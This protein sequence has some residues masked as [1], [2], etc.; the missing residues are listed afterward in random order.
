MKP[1][2]YRNRLCFLAKFLSY[3]VLIRSVV[4]AMVLVFFLPKHACGN[5]NI[6]GVNVA[7]PDETKLDAIAAAVNGNGGSWGYITVVIQETDR[8]TARWNNY[9]SALRERKLIPVVRLATRAEGA[10]WRRPAKEDSGSWVSFLQSLNWVT[11]ERYVILFNEPNNAR[12]WGGAVNPEDYGA[13]AREFATQLNAAS[14]DYVVMLAGFDSAAPTQGTSYLDQVQFLER[15]FATFPQQEIQ[16]NIK[17][18]ASHSYPNPG[19]RGKPN[20]TGRNSIRNYQW[21]L[22]WLAGRG[23]TGKPVFITETGWPVTSYDEQ[24]IATYLEQ[25]Y[26]EVW[27][28]D[29]RVKA[30]TPFLFSYQTAPFDVWA[31]ERPGGGVRPVYDRIKALPKIAGTPVLAD[32]SQDAIDPVVYRFWSDEKRGHFFTISPG[33]RDWVIQTFATSTWRFE[34]SGFSAL[35]TQQAGSIPVYRF[36]SN[37]QQGHFYTANAGEKVYIEKTFPSSVW[38]YETVAFYVF[39]PGT[40]DTRPVYRFWSPLY[41]KHFYTANEGEKQYIESNFP[42]SVWSYEQIAWYVR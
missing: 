38:R 35:A 40:P 4:L 27:F 2:R 7:S 14:P 41:R 12:E 31:W 19:F 18:W 25:A 42:A 5:N 3:S 23:I 24:T 21:E 37:T 33:E 34:G 6:F 9:F 1:V 11:R 8:D 28:R 26:R 20:D 29:S 36:W 13:V 15:M 32:G 10:N 30:V 16:T 17:G 39:P 22:Q